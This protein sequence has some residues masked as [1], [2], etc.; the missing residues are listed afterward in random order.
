MNETET[1]LVKGY[2]CPHDGR[3][4]VLILRA[5]NSWLSNNVSPALQEVRLKDWHIQGH[6]LLLCQGCYEKLIDK[7]RRILGS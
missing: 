4:E 5:D 3:I 6:R 7:A 1:Q 2:S